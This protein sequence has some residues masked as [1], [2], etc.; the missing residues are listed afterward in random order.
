MRGWARIQHPEIWAEDGILIQ[1][2]I[3][4]GWGAL[5]I[6]VAGSYY[7]LQRIIT[8]FL[9]YLPI[10]YL[11]KFIV[12]ADVFIVAAFCSLYARRTYAYLIPAQWLRMLVCFVLCFLPPFHEILGNFANLHWVLF[13]LLAMMGLKDIREKFTVFEIILA[14]LIGFSVGALIC[15]YPVFL[16]RYFEQ[17]RL[18]LKNRCEN[19]TLLILALITFCIL[20]TVIF[21][22][23][24]ALHYDSLIEQVSSFFVQFNMQSIVYQPWLGRKW[25]A[26]LP[27]YPAIDYTLRGIVFFGFFLLT[28]KMKEKLWYRAMLALTLG[29]IVW[30]VLCC[31][32][33][34]GAA[35]TFIGGPYWTFRYAF[36]G[37]VLALIVWPV[38]IVNSCSRSLRPTILAAFFLGMN[39]YF[40]RLFFLIPAYGFDHFW[41][42]SLPSLLPAIRG[43]PSDVL[44]R[45]YPL[46]FDFPFHFQG[47]GKSAHCR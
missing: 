36:L 16:W 3:T 42:K 39:L 2:F 22:K 6:S 24:S 45:A 34:D 43:C 25:A 12:I 7:V 28:R 10:I 30:P 31:I 13:F 47:T 1:K 40:F 11:P 27:Y 8:H 15:L 41:E 26:K 46:G 32:A 38:V 37:M 18:K 29:V 14:A 35:E 44:L 19:G 21:I 5:L 17:R 20:C 4:D 33:R 9:M 23:H